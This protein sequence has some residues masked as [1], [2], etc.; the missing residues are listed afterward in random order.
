M[1]VSG[2]ISGPGGPGSGD[3]NLGEIPK[4][5]EISES[6]NTESSGIVSGSGYDAFAEGTGKS[7]S[8]QESVI[9]SSIGAEFLSDSELGLCKF[10]K[11]Q[12]SASSSGKLKLTSNKS[13]SSRKAFMAGFKSAGTRR[14]YSDP[15][16]SGDKKTKGDGRVL[17]PSDVLESRK[18]KFFSPQT[19][20]LLF[21][22]IG[23]PNVET[24]KEDPFKKSSEFLSTG[25]SVSVP[26]LVSYFEALSRTSSL[27]SVRNSWTTDYMR[28][29]E[30]G[31]L[32]LNFPEESALA[33]RVQEPTTIEE[34]SDVS[35]L[36][37]SFPEP[38]ERQ[39]SP[40][41]SEKKEQALIKEMLLRGDETNNQKD[42]Q[43]EIDEDET[44]EELM[45]QL[46]LSG[47]P[48]GGFPLV[49]GET[50]SGTWSGA[51]S[52]E[53]RIPSNNQASL[54]TIYS[55]GKLSERATSY[56]TT[57]PLVTGLMQ[58]TRINEQQ[59]NTKSDGVINESKSG[60]EQTSVSSFLGEERISNPSMSS[61]YGKSDEKSSKNQDVTLLTSSIFAFGSSSGMSVSLENNNVT[62]K[63]DLSI[64]DRNKDGKGGP[65]NP[66]VYQYRSISIDPPI[67]LRNPVYVSDSRHTLSGK[68]SVIEAGGDY[69]QGRG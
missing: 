38:T 40:I 6:K 46:L 30:L 35:D 45:K 17:L 58:P 28:G 47:M 24:W 25:A 9:R 2:N 1:S 14:S 21:E 10:N 50:V 37:T 27:E 48:P 39:S 44:V 31:S 13:R 68:P 55:S 4:D 11:A 18:P 65:P 69:S 29:G 52:S 54:P 62:E 66:L 61:D 63:I 23:V 20:S 43:G 22:G 12:E 67:I 57:L 3:W 41:S 33:S 59:G 8:K 60:L 56:P 42:A 26:H 16:I 49:G 53:F 36:L 19:A 34:S 15:G 32:T 5:K 51:S 7:T 64:G